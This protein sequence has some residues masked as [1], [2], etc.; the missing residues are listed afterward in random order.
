MNRATLWILDSSSGYLHISLDFAFPIPPYI[1]LDDIS[2]DTGPLIARDRVESNPPTA[3][4]RE[5]ATDPGLDCPSEISESLPALSPFF[6]LAI[7]V[8][9][10]RSPAEL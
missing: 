5:L 2:L 9:R 8:H 3:M 1:S 7:R 6:S 4:A 10:A